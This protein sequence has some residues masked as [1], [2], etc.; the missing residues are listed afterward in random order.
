MGIVSAG[1]SVIC[2]FIAISFLSTN[3]IPLEDEEGPED[4][5]SITY[6]DSPR[7]RKDLS[8][9]SSTELVQ[10]ILPVQVD[11]GSLVSGF[12]E[13]RE[14]MINVDEKLETLKANQARMEEENGQLK[15]QVEENARLIEHLKASIANET[16]AR[17]SLEK[18]TA[19][20]IEQL[21]VF[22]E[23]ETEARN[24]TTA[25]PE[26]PD[27]QTPAPGKY[28]FIDDTMN[29]DAARAECKS[30]GSD[31]ATHLTKEDLD[32]VFSK[33]I[34]SGNLC[35]WIGGR[36]NARATEANFESS[37]EWLDG[38][39]ISVDDGLWRENEPDF[40]SQKCMYIHRGPFTRKDGTRGPAF[41]TAR[42]SDQTFALCQR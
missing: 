21:K 40:L 35:V 25:K 30:R 26:T 34:P 39:R 9:S 23:N 38:H 31:L 42:C 29:W 33:V 3:A 19:R 37:F 22:K 18:E 20:L 32:F 27:S 10:A 5:S 24:A 14:N 13:M 28:V 4:R 16:K 17:K 7:H 2:V 6:A 15:S 36:M 8:D 11:I 12:D 41:Q 1:E